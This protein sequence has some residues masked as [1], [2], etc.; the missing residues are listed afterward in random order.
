MT[1]AADFAEATAA[2]LGP[3]LAPRGFPLQSADTN[4]PDNASVLFHCDGPQVA[5]FLQGCPE[6]YVD[7]LIRTYGGETPRCLDIWVKMEDGDRSFHGEW[8]PRTLTAI[9]GRERVNRLDR[10]RHGPLQAWLDTLVEVLDVFF[11]HLERGGGEPDELQ[12]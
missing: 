2:A 10:A 4:S 9:A 12:D 11:R 3:V 6:W 8:Q 5:S 7:E 1:A